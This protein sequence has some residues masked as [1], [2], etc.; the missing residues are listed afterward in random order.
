MVPKALRL[1]DGRSPNRRALPLQTTVGTLT[2]RFV[3]GN[4]CLHL[5]L[6]L[7]PYFIRFSF[8]YLHTFIVY[9]IRDN[10]IIQ[11]DKIVRQ[12]ITKR[13]SRRLLLEK[14]FSAFYDAYANENWY[15]RYKYQV[16]KPNTQVHTI[17]KV[18]HEYREKL[19][20]ASAIVCRISCVFFLPIHQKCERNRF[21]SEG[22]AEAK[23][24]LQG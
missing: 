4:P 12:A 21:V 16:Y 1:P 23:L 15:H 11:C 8:Y 7:L 14:V 19:T 10:Q 20:K 18:I 3:I 24:S 17:P 13:F 22:K 5:C 9:W 2:R 6:A